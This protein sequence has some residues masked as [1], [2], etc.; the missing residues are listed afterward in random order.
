MAEIDRGQL[1]RDNRKISVQMEQLA[2]RYMAQKGLTVGQAHVLRYILLHTGQGT[3]LTDIPE[4]F[5]CSMA[6]LSCMVKRLREKGYVRAESCA[7]DDRRKLLFA[8]RKGEEVHAYLDEAIGAAQR[9]LYG[10]FSQDELSALD[11]LQQKMLRNLSSLM[12]QTHK[13]VSQS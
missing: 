8:T 10:C 3:S 13:E 5:G 7:D 6:T 9:Q 11:R 2:N 4:E 12:E 1:A